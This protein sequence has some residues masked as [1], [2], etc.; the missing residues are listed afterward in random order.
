MRSPR[1][2]VGSRA[3]GAP[4]GPLQRLAGRRPARLHRSLRKPALESVEEWLAQLGHDLDSPRR[5]L[6][7]V[8]ATPGTE[9]HT[10]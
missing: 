1:G 10:P 8:V 6:I 5:S 9:C 3:V 4:R 7:E 2:T